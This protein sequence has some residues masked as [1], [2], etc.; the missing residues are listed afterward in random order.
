MFVSLPSF[1]GG[2]GRRAAASRA[3][4]RLQAPS[5][6]DD[7]NLYFAKAGLMVLQASTRLRTVRP[8]PLQTLYASP[9]TPRSRSTR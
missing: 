4:D 1:A 7:G 5:G 9:G 8:T 2:T 6:S 3:K